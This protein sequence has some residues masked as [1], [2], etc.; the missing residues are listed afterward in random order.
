MTYGI[1]YQENSAVFMELFDNLASYYRY[2]C[3][4]LLFTSH[5]AF[6]RLRYV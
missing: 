2:I 3:G 4:R 1:M 6:L 5:L